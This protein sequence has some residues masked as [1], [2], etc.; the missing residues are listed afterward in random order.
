MKEITFE[1]LKTGMFI[2]VR[3]GGASP[4]PVLI[5]SIDLTEKT[6]ETLSILV[7]YMGPTGIQV[8][9][10]SFFE[11]L[12]NNDQRAYTITINNIQKQFEQVLTTYLGYMDTVRNCLQQ[13]LELP[14]IENKEETKECLSAQKQQ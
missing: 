7:P 14:A 4:R 3:D 10:H 11:M 2:E 1:E 9:R 8:N 13:K 5:L 12:E 6:I